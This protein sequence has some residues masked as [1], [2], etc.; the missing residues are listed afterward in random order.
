M[1]K[2]KTEAVENT[3]TAPAEVAPAEDVYPLSELKQASRQVF[4][5]PS[6]VVVAALMDTK[7]KEYTVTE[8]RAAIKEFMNKE[9]K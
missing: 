7:K 4:G 8:V 2:T 6:E 1:A 9:V 5:V 3:A